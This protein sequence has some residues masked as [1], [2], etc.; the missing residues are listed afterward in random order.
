MLGLTSGFLTTKAHIKLLE[1]TWHDRKHSVIVQ[2]YKVQESK[3]HTYSLVIGQNTTCTWVQL[4]TEV[5]YS[6]A[7]TSPKIQVNLGAHT[8]QLNF[9]SKHYYIGSIQVAKLL[10]K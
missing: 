3:N 6:C 2:Y 8:K 9:F 10:H 4:Q 7:S 5:I 1:I